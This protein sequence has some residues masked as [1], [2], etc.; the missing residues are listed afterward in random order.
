MGDIVCRFPQINLVGGC[1]GTDKPHL[2]EIA[3]NV[4][5]AKAEL[6]M[7]SHDGW[8]AGLGRVLP[9]VCVLH[10]AQPAGG[11]IK[12]K[13]AFAFDIEHFR[14]GSGGADQPCAGF[15]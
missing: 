15:V 3:Q 10:F 11:A 4:L 14:P 8:A 5:Q 7:V 12:F 2:V 9:P 1:C 6:A 13:T